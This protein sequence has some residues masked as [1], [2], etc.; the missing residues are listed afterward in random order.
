MFAAFAAA[1][2]SNNARSIAFDKVV[3]LRTLYPTTQ[4][5]PPTNINDIPQSTS[6]KPLKVRESV[7]TTRLLC[8][9][10][11]PSSAHAQVSPYTVLLEF[12]YT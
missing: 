5:I 6:K 4:N 11:S 1:V 8:V 9:S 12:R 10:D 2:I 3:Q 7:I